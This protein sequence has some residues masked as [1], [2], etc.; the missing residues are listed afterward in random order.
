MEV[1]KENR[2]CKQTEDVILKQN[3]AGIISTT[4]KDACYKVK[5]ADLHIPKT[6]WHASREVLYKCIRDEAFR[7]FVCLLTLHLFT[8]SS[9]LYMIY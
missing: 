5:T 9:I 6:N 1:R 7:W 8:S 2:V 4:H 3:F